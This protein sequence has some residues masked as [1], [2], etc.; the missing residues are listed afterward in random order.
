MLNNMLTFCLG[1]ACDSSVA[2]SPCSG[3][4]TLPEDSGVEVGQES[5]Q[6]VTS[7]LNPGAAVGDSSNQKQGA[8]TE[9]LSFFTSAK[10]PSHDGKEIRSAMQSGGLSVQ[11]WGDIGSK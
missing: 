7:S 4:P 8:V 9:G 5:E 11:E 10:R 2:E 3:G 6:E 1:G